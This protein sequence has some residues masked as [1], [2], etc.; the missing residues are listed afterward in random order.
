M[1]E[2]REELPVGLRHVGAALE[3]ALDD[4]RQGGALH[5]ADREEVGAKAAGRKGDGAGERRAPDEVDVLAGRACVREVVREL[6]EIRERPLDLVLGEG[7]V[8]GALDGRTMGEWRLRGLGPVADRGRVHLGD[9]LQRLH[10]DQLALAVVV[11]RDDDLPGVLRDL[12]DRLHDVLVGRLLHDPGVD[13]LVEI[14]LLPVRVVVGERR[15]EDMA[16]EA[17][18]HVVAG[19]VRPGVKRHLVRG[20]GL[21]L[22]AAQDLGDLLR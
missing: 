15:A 1:L 19:A 7:G 16:L 21:R 6:V 22:A 5:P 13:Q 11:G 3:L 2:A 9:L 10:A 4:Q 8:A 14:G 18:R 12:A 20:V 17:D